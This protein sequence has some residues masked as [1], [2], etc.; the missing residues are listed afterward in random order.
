MGADHSHY[1]MLACGV[2]IDKFR[3]LYHNADM[4]A[5]IVLAEPRTFRLMTAKRS[6]VLVQSCWSHT[7]QNSAKLHRSLKIDIAWKMLLLPT[8][9]ENLNGLFEHLCQIP[10]TK[11]YTRFG[12]SQNRFEDRLTG[13]LNFREPKK[14]A[15]QIVYIIISVSCKQALVKLCSILR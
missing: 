5:H 14:S 8:I 9:H 7:K 1:A 2:D 15:L 6:R 12:S 4:S 11:L 10:R 3:H 13:F